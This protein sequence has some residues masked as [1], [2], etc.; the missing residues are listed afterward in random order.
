MRDILWTLG[1][2]Q[3][4]TNAKFANIFENTPQADD[5]YTSW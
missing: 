1:A 3:N 2:E 5:N 4:F